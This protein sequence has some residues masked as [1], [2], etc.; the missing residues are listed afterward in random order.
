MRPRL[1]ATLS[2]LPRRPARRRSG[3]RVVVMSARDRSGGLLVGQS[4]FPCLLGQA[5]VRV[6]KREGDGATPA[7]IWR[8]LA[9]LYRPDRQRHPNGG[10]CCH[11]IEKTDGW[12]DDP[13]SRR[14]NEPVKRPFAGSHEA[15]WRKDK[16]YDQVIVLDHN[17]GPI[18]TARGSAI[19]IHLTAPNH[20]P[21]AGCIALSEPDLRRVLSRAGLD[22]SIAVGVGLG[23]GANWQ[24]RRR[25]AR[26]RRRS[27]S[28]HALR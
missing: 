10:F 12:C 19:F 17:Q 21:T 6:A 23:G 18:V 7:G 11:V 22:W 1:R 25:A 27:L 26:G 28:R 9:L 20:Q 5:G 2:P 13:R 3:F 4:R 8:P 24:V 14:Y 15:L 16:V